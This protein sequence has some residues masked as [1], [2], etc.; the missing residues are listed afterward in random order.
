MVHFQKRSA[1]QF[2]QFSPE[3]VNFQ[4]RS[5]GCRV[6][7][8]GR[9]GSGRVGR[10]PIRFFDLI[11]NATKS[12]KIGENVQSV[13]RVGDVWRILANRRLEGQCRLCLKLKK[14]VVACTYLAS[15]PFRPHSTLV[16]S[17][18]SP[19]P[20]G[21]S[22][23]RPGGQRR[24]SVYREKGKNEAIHSFMKRSV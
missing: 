7:R 17:S 6:G 3:M 4:I 11:L 15:F 20:P 10:S 12:A 21:F 19:E 8:V 16:C 5:E 14:N 18:V 9:V 24:G 22:L 23:F 13:L 1:P 2:H